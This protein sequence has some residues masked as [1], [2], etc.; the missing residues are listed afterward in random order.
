M[1]TITS[2]KNTGAISKKFAVITCL[3]IAAAGLPA[4][5]LPLKDLKD[6]RGRAI[7]KYQ[8]WGG[9]GPFI[10]GGTNSF[11][12]G[13]LINSPQVSDTPE[14]PLTLDALSKNENARCCKFNFNPDTEYVI[15]WRDKFNP[16]SGWAYEVFDH[17]PFDIDVLPRKNLPDSDALFLKGVKSLCVLFLKRDSSS[18]PY[19]EK[20]R[21]MAESLQIK[22]DFYNFEGGVIKPE[23]AIHMNETLFS[24]SIKT[25]DD[26]HAIFKTFFESWVSFERINTEAAKAKIIFSLE[27]GCKRCSEKIIFDNFLKDKK[28]RCLDLIMKKGTEYS[29]FFMRDDFDPIKGYRVKIF[30][31]IPCHLIGLL[32]TF[33]KGN[34]DAPSSLYFLQGV[35]SYCLLYWKPGSDRS[36]KLYYSLIDIREKTLGQPYIWMRPMTVDADILDNTNG[37]IALSGVLG[38]E[39]YDDN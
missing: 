17:R 9:T 33:E 28:A 13:V 7:L 4:Q 38:P 23:P 32:Q 26:I 11:R 31:N 22:L 29:V 30:E 35:K 37:F 25:D 10:S 21:Q 8:F 24:R 1:W 12:L 19:D 27:N 36:V 15:V 39:D 34:S 20:G 14:A 5:T 3:I 2:Y 18:T 16:Q 6:N